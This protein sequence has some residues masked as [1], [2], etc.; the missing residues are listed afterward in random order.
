MIGELG[1]IIAGIVIA[2]LAVAVGIGGGILWTPLLI[3]GYG[4]SP[5]QAVATS[6][7]IQVVGMGSGSFAYLRTQLVEKKLSSVVFS[8]GSAGSGFGQFLYRQAARRSRTNG[9]GRHG[10]HS[11]FAVRIQP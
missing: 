4:L 10:A 6:L 1:L 9:P 3:L 7:I 5:Q 8:G 2:G 11:G